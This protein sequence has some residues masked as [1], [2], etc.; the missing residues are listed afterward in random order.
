MK[1]FK[2]RKPSGRYLYCKAC[3]TEKTEFKAPLVIFKG[4]GFSKNADKKPFVKFHD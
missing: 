3:E 1:C 2:C 4:E